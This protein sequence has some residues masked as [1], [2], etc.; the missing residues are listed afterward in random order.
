MHAVLHYLGMG[1]HHFTYL[2]QAVAFCFA[3]TLPLG[4]LGLIA[5]AAWEARRRKLGTAAKPGSARALV[6][7]RFAPAAE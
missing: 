1:H 4:T 5:G 3:A 2:E 6:T 7:A